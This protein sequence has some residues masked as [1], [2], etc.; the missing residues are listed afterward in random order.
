[1]SLV[2]RSKTHPVR[3]LDELLKQLR[4]GARAV[5]VSVAQ[6]EGSTPREVDAWMAVLADATVGTVGGGQ[7]EWQA[8]RH[9]RQLLVDAGGALRQRYPLGPSLGQCCGGV[10]HLAFERLDGASAD[11][12]RKRLAGHRRHLAVFGGGHVGQALVRMAGELPLTIRWIDSRDEPPLQGSVPLRCEHSDPPQAAVRD[13][14]AGASVLIMTHSHAEDLEIVATCLARQRDQG[15]LG[16]IGLIG[17]D[18][19]WASFRQRLLAR[20]LSDDDLRRVTC[21]I[22]V[23]GIQ[24]KQPAVVA[25]AALAQVMQTVTPAR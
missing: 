22:G 25:L 3:D 4:Q 21:P 20:G 16:Y 9:A 7:L 5:L 18:T 8:M 23:P 19:K 13:L 6:T 17:S 12:L 1:M 10:V 11:T 15:D 14:P 24:G 2:N